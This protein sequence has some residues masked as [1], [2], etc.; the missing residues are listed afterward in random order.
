MGFGAGAAAEF[1]R[2][3]N[4]HVGANLCLAAYL[5]WYGAFLDSSGRLVG[6][7]AWG[8]VAPFLGLGARRCWRRATS[9]GNQNRAFE[10]TVWQLAWLRDM[11]HTDVN[12]E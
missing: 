2:A 6:G 5:W 11:T 10:G 12:A 4:C 7:V 8:Y 1:M 3:Q 9:V